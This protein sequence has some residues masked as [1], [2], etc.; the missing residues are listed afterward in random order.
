M[1][2]LRGRFEKNLEKEAEEF[3]SSF[4]FD[5]RLYAYDIAGSI[6]HAKML[7]KCKIISKSDCAKIVK[8]LNQIKK[9]LDNS[10][11][12][13]DESADDIHMAI[14]SLLIK[15]AGDAG[16]KLHTGRSRNDQVAL[17]MHLF[18]KDEVIKIIGLV[19]NFQSVIV[20]KAKININVIM[21]GYTH[22]QHAQPILFSQH[23]MAYFWMLE[24]DKERLNDSLKR[25]DVMPL[26]AA[27]LAGTSLP[28]DRKY[29][30]KALGFS[31]I[32]ENSI[33]S[34]S[35]R[36][37]VI[38]LAANL[39]I[40]M[41]HLSRFSEDIVLWSSK[42]FD[43]IE[44]DD[45]YCTGSSIMPQKK[46]PDLPE[47]VR[48][49]TGRVTGS[50]V[51]LIVMMKGLPLSY[52]RDMQEDKEAIFD[53]VDTVK[54]CLKIFSSL[55]KK[56]KI[57]SRQMYLKADDGFSIATDISEYLVKKGIPFRKS[58]TL[59]A[60][61]VKYCISKQIKPKDLKISELKKFSDKFS[62]DIYRVLKAENS[63]NAKR[64]AGSTS[65]SS[66]LAQIKN[67][68]SLL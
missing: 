20:D 29:T 63:V 64:S 57:N 13:L 24:Q 46:N 49:K 56:M 23:I 22:L 44:I 68:K 21:P 7:A 60:Q 27:A 31:K 6:A 62:G 12:K 14:E 28:I 1:K 39:S 16:R 19:N 54:G 9:G 45:S 11:I 65:T 32:S 18:I 8:G 10:K 53:A 66:V 33:D 35:D 47:L 15:K 58:Y 41:V 50:L 51:S 43:F 26:G 30:A 59:T 37:F 55:I 34:V 36:D 5:K 48:G 61:L 40:I 38:E 3:S 4:K 25:I 67:A 52:N 17:D 42:E 2:L